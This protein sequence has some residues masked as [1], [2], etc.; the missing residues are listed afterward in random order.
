[1]LCSHTSARRSRAW[2]QIPNCICVEKQEISQAS[3]LLMLYAFCCMR[4][5]FDLVFLLQLN[6]DLH[7]KMKWT[8][9]SYEHNM[10]GAG[11]AVRIEW[12]HTANVYSMAYCCSLFAIPIGI[13]LFNVWH[14]RAYIQF[15]YAVLRWLNLR[16][17]FVC[18]K[19]SKILNNFLVVDVVA[20]VVRI[21]V[22]WLDVR[23]AQRI[24]IFIGQQNIVYMHLVYVWVFGLIWNSFQKT[25]NHLRSIGSP[26]N[27][28][29]K[30]T[31]LCIV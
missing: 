26:I 6:S 27:Y 30:Y 5:R 14:M 7:R 25:S 10:K 4:L 31:H 8:Y 17:I 20:V 11:L 29:M 3:Y 16:K 13:M 21:F 24:S 28:A 9:C 18:G 23:T 15:H 19:A 22:I 1:M 2:Q 12:Q